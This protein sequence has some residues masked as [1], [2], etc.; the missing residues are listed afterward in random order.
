MHARTLALVAFA[1]CLVAPGA[2]AKSPVAIASSMPPAD[3]RLHYL[4]AAKFVAQRMV[5]AP[6]AAG[7]AAEALDLTRLRA[8]IA[9]A[10]PDRMAQA[11]WDGGHE[12]PSLFSA[13]IDRDLTK[14]PAT[15]ALLTLIGKET[16]VVLDQGKDFFARKRPYSVDSTLPAC[17]KDRMS[18]PAR[19]Y[20]SGHAGIGYAIGWTLASLLPEQAPQILARADDY[21]LSR[22]ICGVHFH[23]DTEASHVI[24]TLAAAT[25]LKDR[26]LARQIAAARAELAG[27]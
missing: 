9:A 4:D 6:P 2:I 1:A 3:A 16:D 7:S 14:L 13:T 19:S 24:G 23:A 8:L 22:E 15:W 20:P 21:A 11:Q 10:T 12:D 18:K 17:V 25:L 27:H 5:A 26:R